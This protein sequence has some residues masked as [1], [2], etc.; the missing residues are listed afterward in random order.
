MKKNKYILLLSLFCLTLCLSFVSCDKDDDKD[1]VTIAIENDVDKDGVLKYEL[2]RPGEA[3]VV[4]DASYAKLTNVTIHALA[5]VEGDL[6]H[7]IIADGAFA[8]VTALETVTINEGVTVIGTEAFAGCTGLTDV[9]LKGLHTILTISDK[10]FLG[11]SALK[12]IAIPPYVKVIGKRTFK[13]CSS[14]TNINLENIEVIKEAA[15][16]NCSALKEVVLPEQGEITI[17]D[18]VFLLCTSLEVIS[19]PEEVTK[20]GK[21]VFYGCSNLGQ[22]FSMPG[23]TS[24]GTSTFMGCTALP[25]EIFTT[26]LASIGSQAFALCNFTEVVLKDCSS[27]DASAFYGNANLTK[28][29]LTGSASKNFKSAF[30]V[31]QRFVCPVTEVEV[32]DGTVGINAFEE[33]DMTKIILNENVTGIAEDAF[34]YS[35]IT[36]MDIPAKVTSIGYE[37][38]YQCSDLAKVI[39]RAT[40]PP[41]LG[42]RIENNGGGVFPATVFAGINASCILYVPDGPKTTPNQYVDAYT[43]AGWDAFFGG[44]IKKISELPK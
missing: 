24:V 26:K 14:L 39:V 6:C 33:T 2:V 1:E 36:E 18:S 21:A 20:L 22:N 12:N 4:A 38:F 29:K 9:N 8:G 23:V 25:N 43:T 17:G 10:A 3:Q 11:C 27:L 44:G 13:G 32:L 31:G 16:F 5:E 35:S 19:L 42:A 40:T 30:T 34:F 28:F 41:A 37:A 7:I 15:F